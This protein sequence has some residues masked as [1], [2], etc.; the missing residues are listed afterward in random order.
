M[1]NQADILLY[2]WKE[3][4]NQA[5]H[6]ASQWADGAPASAARKSTAECS[7]P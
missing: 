2:F 4:R 3:Q 1:A 6:I 7:S 5:R